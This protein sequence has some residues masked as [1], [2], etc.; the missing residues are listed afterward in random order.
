MNQQIQFVAKENPEQF[1]N[2]KLVINSFYLTAQSQLATR[3]VTIAYNVPDL[4]DLHARLTAGRKRRRTRRTSH[5]VHFRLPKELIENLRA[6]AH[7]QGRTLSSFLAC[8]AIEVQWP[9]FLAM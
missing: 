6:V 9:I 4:R 3:N 5:Y 2:L 1:K 7:C 8:A